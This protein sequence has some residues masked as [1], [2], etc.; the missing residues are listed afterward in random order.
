MP[1]TTRRR[2]L[3]GLSATSLVGLAGCPS[4]TTSGPP[5]GSL[6]FRNDDDVPH[7]LTLRVTDVGTNRGEDPGTVTGEPIVTPGQQSLTASTSIQPG[8]QRTYESV[9]T[10]SLWYAVEFAVD[11]E[12][13]REEVGEV[14][15]NPAPATADSGRFLTAKVDE[16]GRFGWLITTTENTADIE[17]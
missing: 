12:P 16:S 5:A 17:R 7:V 3:A 9:F 13:P 6:R 2:L 8:E 15:F 1:S 11:G 4:V 10:R 14:T